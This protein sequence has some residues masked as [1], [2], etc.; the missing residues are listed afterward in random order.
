MGYVGMVYIWGKLGVLKHGVHVFGCGP[1]TSSRQ[2]PVMTSFFFSFRKG[3]RRTQGIRQEHRCRLPRSRDSSLTFPAR[4]QSSLELQSARNLGTKVQL[5]SSQ[6]TSHCH[7]GKFSAV[8]TPPPS[9][10]SSSSLSSSS[11]NLQMVGFLKYLAYASLDPMG[12]IARFG[13][14]LQVLPL[15]EAD[16][17]CLTRRPRT[18]L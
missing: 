2:P 8:A 9:S 4:S 10:S 6:C 7:E 14:S 17:Q 13:S 5:C 16:K 1:T 11:A 12:D 15:T 18:E 3:S